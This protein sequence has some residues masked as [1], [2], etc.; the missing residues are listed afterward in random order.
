MRLTYSLV[1]FLLLSAISTISYAQQRLIGV[2][3][4]EKDQAKLHQAAVAL[5]NPK[6]SILI[7]FDRTKENG[8]F[9]IL[10]LDT[11]M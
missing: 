5:L 2:V 9:Q 8:A 4:D 7:K 11:G 10:N 1:L 6:D 3:V